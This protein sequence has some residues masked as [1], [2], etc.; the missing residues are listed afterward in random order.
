MTNNFE[1][2]KKAFEE[3]LENNCD[4]SIYEFIEET[5]NIPFGG[6]IVFEEADDVS[7]SYNYTDE[8]LTKIYQFKDFGNIYIKF[9]GTNQ[10]YN[11]T[12]W[13]K[14]YTEVIPKQK[15]IQVYEAI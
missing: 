15:E 8:N 10:S 12:D 6:K 1:K 14:S 5:S 7:D 9:T 2:F 4:G 13:E 3:Y 11:G